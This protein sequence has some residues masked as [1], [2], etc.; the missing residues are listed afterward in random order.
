MFLLLLA[1]AIP[2][3][4][5]VL[6]YELEGK[7]FYSELVKAITASLLLFGPATFYVL[8]IFFAR[9]YSKHKTLQSREPEMFNANSSIV[10]KQSAVKI[11]FMSFACFGLELSGAIFMTTDSEKTHGV[12]FMLLLFG[13]LVM[14]LNLLKLIA[15]EGDLILSKDGFIDKRLISWK[16]VLWADVEGMSVYSIKAV[17]FISVILKNTSQHKRKQ[18]FMQKL[19]GSKHKISIA[20]LLLKIEADDLLDLMRAYHNKYGNT[21]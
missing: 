2:A 7:I 5:L 21:S 14:I 12:G 16:P 10:I 15:T 3:S 8:F 13:A 18:G 20:V 19:F 1:V 17:Y 11:I 4:I 6:D 9:I